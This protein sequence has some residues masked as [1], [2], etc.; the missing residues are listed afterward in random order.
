[1]VLTPLLFLADLQQRALRLP[2][3]GSVRGP[4]LSRVGEGVGPLQVHVQM[5]PVNPATVLVQI[6]IRLHK[7]LQ[8]STSLSLGDAYVPIYFLFILTFSQQQLLSPKSGHIATRETEITASYV[9]HFYCSLTFQGGI[10]E[11]N[12]SRRIHNKLDKK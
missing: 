5:P 11:G 2:V 1:M 9:Y 12:F 4:G 7:Q 6:C 8:V 10:L 3:Q